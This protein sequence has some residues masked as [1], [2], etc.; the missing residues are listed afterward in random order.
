M[1]RLALPGD[2]LWSIRDGLTGEAARLVTE[3]MF[4][5]GAESVDAWAAAAVS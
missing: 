5:E 2:R 4:A 3:L 1:N